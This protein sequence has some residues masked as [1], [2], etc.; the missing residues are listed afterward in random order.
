[1]TK[2]MQVHS[3]QK[4]RLAFIA[5]TGFCALSLLDWTGVTGRSFP[6]SWSEALI[7]ICINIGW[8][9]LFTV[10]SYFLLVRPFPRK[11]STDN[12]QGSAQ[13]PHRRQ[14]QEDARDR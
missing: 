13:A 14:R 7:Q 11:L 10:A 8:T 9:I 1:V 6:R 4:K 12:S 2:G 3:S 5:I